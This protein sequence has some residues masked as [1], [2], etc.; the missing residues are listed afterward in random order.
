MNPYISDILSQP[1][2]FL[3]KYCFSC[4]L[5]IRPHRKDISHEHNPD[6]PRKS[7]PYIIAHRLT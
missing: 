1:P 4:P 3:A 2:P 7:N 5:F 6:A